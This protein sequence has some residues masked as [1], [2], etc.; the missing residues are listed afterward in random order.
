MMKRWIV[1]VL[2][3]SSVS[4][5]AADTVAGP[6]GGK[7]LEL[8][9]TDAEFFVNS[10]RQ[11]E[12]TFYDSTLSPV[13]PGTHEV[14]VIVEDAGVKTP[15]T[16]V[17]VDAVMTATEPLSEGVGHNIVVQ[18]KPDAESKNHNFRLVYDSHICGGC[19]LAEYACTCEHGGGED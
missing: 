8:G 5:Y 17:T 6:K 4:L 16:L 14:K 13:A 9:D 11:V 18:I 12:I 7:L 2:L 10:N 19:H 1:A 15:L 3:M